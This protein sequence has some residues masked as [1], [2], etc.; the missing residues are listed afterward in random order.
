MELRTNDDMRTMFSIFT[1]YMTKGPIEQ[2][3]MLVTSVEA[4]LSNTISSMRLS[5][6]NEIVALMVKPGEDEVEEINLSD[7]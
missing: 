4:I 3:A 5:T 2:D 7:P 6:F 1:R